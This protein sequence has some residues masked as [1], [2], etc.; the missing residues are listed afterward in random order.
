MMMFD[1][2]SSGKLKPI[3]AGHLQSEQ[4]GQSGVLITES[5]NSQALNV[6]VS[7]QVSFEKTDRNTRTVN[8]TRGKTEGHPIVS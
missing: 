4:V 3:D 7:E 2:L 1:R 6:N 8:R 5:G